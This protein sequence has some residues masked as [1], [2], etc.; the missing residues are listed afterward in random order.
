MGRL[1]TT[2]AREFRAIK[3]LWYRG[4]DSARLRE[5]VGDLLS[6]H[7]RAAARRCPQ[8]PSYG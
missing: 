3:E 1:S 7:P 6:R 2:H 8:T 5:R 4:L